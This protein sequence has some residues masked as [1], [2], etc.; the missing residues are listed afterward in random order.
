MATMFVVLGILTYY[1]APT[2]FLFKDF[3]IFFLIIN[4]VLIMMVVGLTFLA[5]LVLPYVQKLLVNILLMLMPTD[6]RLKGLIYKSMETNKKRNTN[7]AIMF[8]LCLS[9]L[10]FAGS[11]FELFAIL[12]TSGLESQLGTDLYGV[13]FDS[14]T[15]NEF[16]DEGPIAAFLQEQQDIDGAVVGW[17]FSS[18]SLK[19]LLRKFDPIEKR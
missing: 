14:V 9:F 6:W 7:T 17:T 5:V 18:P 8:A 2:A 3:A 19:Y 4:G 16:I 1:V 11:A 12:I 15:L 13:T 10:I